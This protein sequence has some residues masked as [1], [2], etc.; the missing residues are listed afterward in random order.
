MLFNKDSFLAYAQAKGLEIE[1]E[2]IS[3]LA[4]DVEYRVKELCQEAAKFMLFSKRT[5]LSIDD[6]NNALTT[7]NVDPIFG[8]DPKDNLV[9][10]N[11]IVKSAIFYVPDEEIDLEDLLNQPPPKMPLKPKITSHWLAIEGV[12]PQIPQNPIIMEKPSLKQ[13]PLVTYTEE[14]ELKQTTKHVISK[15]LQLYYEKILSFLEDSEKI[16]LAIEC[17]KTESGIQQLIP[18]LIQN[19]NEK[20]LKNMESEVL[21]NF[22]LFYHSLLQN[23]HIFI[24]PYLHQIIPSLLTCII[25]KRIKNMDI[26]KLAAETIKYVYDKYSITYDT[27]GPRIIKTLS[28]VWLD[29]DKSEDAH[30][31]A[32]FT[33][34][35]LSTNVISSVIQK[36]KDRYVEMVKDLNYE[37]V[38][39]LLNDIL[40]KS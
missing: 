5:K 35:I 7:R 36:E 40:A 19:I 26:R 15:E 33:L 22:I 11:D 34:S 24:D 32:L 12:Q 37:N 13:D 6:V 10:K 4:Q 38:L 17:L 23:E 14:S 16:T 8:Y 27:L 3:I 9:F 21:S 39:Q 30:Y 2:A 25:G 1:D 31:A 20:I 18:Y 29:K 28:K